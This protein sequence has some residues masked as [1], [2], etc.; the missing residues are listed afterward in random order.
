MVM[1]GLTAGK[2]LLFCQIAMGDQS[3]FENRSVSGS[4]G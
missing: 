3:G 2:N 4:L 1:H